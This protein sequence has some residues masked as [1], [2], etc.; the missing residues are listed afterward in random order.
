M[1]VAIESFL[2]LLEGVMGVRLSSLFSKG[3]AMMP[4][5][6]IAISTSHTLKLA[7]LPTLFSQP[8]PRGSVRS[9]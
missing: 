1:M 3:I 2:S 4:L 9:V 5:R 6:V 7:Q 8:M